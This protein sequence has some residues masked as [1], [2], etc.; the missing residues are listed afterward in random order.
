MSNTYHL[1]GRIIEAVTIDFWSTIAG[2]ENV[3]ERKFLRRK[4]AHDWLLERDVD[5]SLD[6]VLATMD[7]FNDY[8]HKTWL[9]DRLTLGA[10][11]AVD[12]LLDH[13]P[14]SVTNG[15][16]LNLAVR[17]DRVMLDA[18]PNLSEG[19]AEALESLS[20]RF[21]IALV[22]DTG[23]TGGETIQ[24]WL[25]Q[26][27]LLPHFTAT[28]F[29]DAVGVAKPHAKMFTT[30]LEALKTPR[31]R[32]VHIGDLDETDIMGSKS[33]GMAAIRYDGVKAKVDCKKC[34]MADLVLDSWSDILHQ[35]TDNGV[36][37][38]GGISL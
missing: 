6:D 7:S 5:V 3:Q 16:R 18:P 32:A 26:R 31:N 23:L 37:L 19:C 35:L 2:G 17:L 15:E 34:S 33:I 38:P 12:F 36:A 4:Y 9:S 22:C 25:K 28:I 13:H 21:P 29:S 10:L 27:G 1:N 20:Q 24:F 30:A 11:D 14:V 8:W